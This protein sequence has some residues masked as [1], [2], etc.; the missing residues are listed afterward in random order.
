MR[1]LIFFAGFMLGNIFG[2]VTMCLFQVN[3]INHAMGKEDK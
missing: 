1:W 2:V 3:R